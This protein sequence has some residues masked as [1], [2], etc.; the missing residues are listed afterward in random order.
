M[1]KLKVLQSITKEEK[2]KTYWANIPKHQYLVIQIDNG[3]SLYIDESE[4]PRFKKALTTLNGYIKPEK[5][6]DTK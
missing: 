1:T 4:L 2:I 5:E 6:T 3:L